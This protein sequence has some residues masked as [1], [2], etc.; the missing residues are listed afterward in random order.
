VH[1]G[2]PC[3]IERVRENEGFRGETANPS[4]SALITLITSY[5]LAIPFQKF[6]MYGHHL[7]K[8]LAQKQLTARP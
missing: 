1:L 2:K 7:G 5:L 8:V 4:A 3:G 6:E